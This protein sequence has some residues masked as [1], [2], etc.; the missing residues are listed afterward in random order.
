MNFIDQV[1]ETYGVIMSVVR[2]DDEGVLM[3]ESDFAL[4]QDHYEELMSRIR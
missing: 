1:D 2:E 3:P 4:Q